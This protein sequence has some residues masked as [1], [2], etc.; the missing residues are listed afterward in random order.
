[1]VGEGGLVAGDEISMAIGCW[2][3]Q[4]SPPL[5]PA[6]TAPG[7]APPTESLVAASA[8]LAAGTTAT[9]VAPAVGSHHK[10]KNKTK[11]IPKFITNQE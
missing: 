3:V 11:R 8:A 5:P 10:I 7:M 4:C 1:M 9:L 2:V 6:G